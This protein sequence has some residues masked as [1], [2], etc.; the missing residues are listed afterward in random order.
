MIDLRNDEP[1]RLRDAR[2]RFGER[3][4]GS[5]VSLAT[6]HRWIKQEKLEVVE[7]GGMVFTTAEAIRRFIE[8]CSAATPGDKA[9]S[10]GPAE[11]VRRRSRRAVQAAAADKA[12]LYP[13]PKRARRRAA[14]A[15]K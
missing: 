9:G 15:A 13:E 10:T 2:G 5:P 7:V 11:T 4:G 14:S 1:I 3:R 6:L 8:G 12:A